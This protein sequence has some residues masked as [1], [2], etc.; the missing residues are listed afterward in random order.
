MNENVFVKE[1]EFKKPL[2]QKI[3]C[4]FD[5]CISDCHN[6]Y[7]HTFDDTCVYDINFT[8]ITNIETVNFTIS[9]RNMCLYDLNKKLTVIRQNG[10]IF[11]Q[12]KKLTKKNI[13]PYLM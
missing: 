13:V 6:K 2:I 10:F 8:N 4:I 7:F 12:I 5:D 1:Y 3:D 11:N 9:N